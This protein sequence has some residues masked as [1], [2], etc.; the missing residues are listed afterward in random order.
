[1][2]NKPKAFIILGNQLFPLSQLKNFKDHHF[3]MAEDYQLCTYVKHHRQKILLFLSAMRSYADELKKANFSLTYFD[4]KHELFKKSYEEKILVFLKKIKAKEVSLF[5]IEDKFFENQ[6]KTFFKKNNIEYHFIN[7]PMFLS[8][9]GD[10]KEYLEMNKKPFMA[11]FYKIQRMKHNILMKNKQEPLGGKWSFDEDNRNKLDP[12]VQ[13]PNLITFKETTHT[14]NI[15]KFL[16]K[17]FNDHPGTLEDF[18]YPT[19]R[20]DALNLFFDFLKKKLNLF[21]DFEDAISQKSHVLFHSM[22]SPIINLGLITP[23]ELVKETLAFAKTN[24]VKINCLE[25]YLRQIIGWREF[26][27]GIYQNY[28]SKMA[29]T[30]F[31]KHH[32]K[33]KNSWY[34]GTTGIDPLDHTIKNCIK[35]GWT[36]HIERLMVV[37]N[38]MNLSNIEPKLVYRW[39]MEMYVD[40][41]DWVMAPNVYG[42]GLFSDGGIFATKPYICASSYLLKMSDFKRGDWCDV[43]DGLY[44]RF[45]EKNK[46]FFSKNY[47]LSMMVKILEKMDREKKQRIYLAAENFIKNNTTS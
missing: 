6:L 14:K 17:N 44:W 28:E 24:K 45:I 11:N 10:F 30:N 26:M 20:K 41:S 22:L 37:A 42:M 36:H 15:K 8:S 27:R 1:M 31:F 4:C 34:D 32:K 2:I 38:I 3:M 23:D 47:R 39:F 43:M 18:N 40:S 21:G 25:G 19:T 46:N 33:L 35:Y 29:T 12:K 7:S 16:E 13:I 5:E 9:R